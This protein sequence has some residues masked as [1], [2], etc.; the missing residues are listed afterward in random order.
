L[1]LT[2]FD[3]RFGG[4]VVPVVGAASV[5][6]CHKVR[7]Q[8]DFNLHE[9]RVLFVGVVVSGIRAAPLVGKSFYW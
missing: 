3:T 5:D 7:Y 8:L 9:A 6:L 4:L 1:S 2:A